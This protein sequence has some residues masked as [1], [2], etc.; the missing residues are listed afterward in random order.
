VGHEA[1]G[2]FLVAALLSCSGCYLIHGRERPRDAAIEDVSVD[3]VAD[4]PDAT[5]DATVDTAPDTMDSA[6]VPDTSM[7]TGCDTEIVVVDAGSV[8]ISLDMLFVVDNSGSMAEEQAAL[9]REFPRMVRALVTG[10]LDGD[11]DREFDPVTDLRVGVITSEVATGHDIVGCTISAFGGDDGI[12]RTQSLPFGGCGTTYPAFLEFVPSRD[13]DPTDFVS[14]FAC[15]G[16][17]GVGG[18]HYEQPLEAALKALTPSA[19]PIRFLAGA[20]RGDTTNAGFLREHSVKMV[21]LVTD[22]DDCSTSDAALFD[23]DS[24]EY[25][26]MDERGELQCF[27][28]PDALFPASR[29]VDGFR[30]LSADDP[31]GFLFAAITGVPPDLVRDP[32]AID[33]DVILADPRM[34]QRVDP[35]VR[36]RAALVRA[37]ATGETGGADPARRIVE[38]ARDLGGSAVVQSICD[39]TFTAALNGVTTQL[40]GVIRRR[41]CRGE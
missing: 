20:G 8:D 22:E 9:T 35:D 14:D 26:H 6:V 1:K 19:S 7:D 5:M 11:G 41:R 25:P 29:Y 39:S 24:A 40:A 10:D 12:L 28:Y 21:L 27:H 36:D 15:V 32:T 18:C 38:V 16:V 13:G 30:A 17:V 4:A 31:D 2:L 23:P 3:A 37:C 34:R 33:F